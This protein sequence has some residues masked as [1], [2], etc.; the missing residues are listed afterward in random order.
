MASKLA[1]QLP[2]FLIKKAIQMVIK[3]S[4]EQINFFNLIEQSGTASDVS[5]KLVIRIS[6]MGSNTG[7]AVQ[8]GK[9]V[10]VDKVE[11]PDTIFSMTKNTFS[12]IIMGKLDHRQ[13]YFLGVIEADGSNWVR[14]SILLAKIFDAIKEAMGTK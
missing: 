11:K 3:K 14:D 5:K 10:E 4:N 2:D 13:A 9:L 8:D 6:D 12:N 7:L 1:I